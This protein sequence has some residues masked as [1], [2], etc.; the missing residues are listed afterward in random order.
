MY[1]IERE[2]N[3][4]EH[5]FY[6]N[7]DIES[8]IGYERIISEIKRKIQETGRDKV[9]VVI[10]CFYGIDQKTLADCLASQL[11]AETVIDSE[12]AKLPEKEVFRK[13]E[14]FIVPKDR[15]WGVM[16]V[17]TVDEFFNPDMISELRDRIEKAEG[18]VVVYGTAASVIT[19]GDILVY[20][21]IPTMLLRG[22]LA[23]GL[24]NWGAGNFEEEQLRK[25]KRSMFV[26]W[27][28]LNKHKLPLLQVMDYYIDYSDEKEP[29]MLTKETLFEVVRSLSERPFQLVPIFMK[30]VW[31]GHWMQKV[32]GVHQN[33][34]NLGWGLTGHMNIQYLTVRTKGKDML[35]NGEDLLFIEPKKMLGNSIFYLWGYRCPVTTNY[36]DTWGGGNLSLQVHAPFWYVQQYLNGTNGHHESYYMM[37]T[38]DHSSVYL[39]LKTGTKVKEMVAD[40][41]KAQDTGGKFDDE[42]YVNHIPMKKHQHVFIPGGTVHCSGEGTCVLEIDQYTIATFKL[43]DWGRVDLD[44]KPRPI[45]IDHGQHCI[46]E[47]FQTEFVY[48]NLIAKQPQIAEGDGWRCDDTSA[49]NYEPMK[50]HRYWISKSVDIVCH[51]AIQILV[52]VEGEEAVIESV[53]GSFEPFTVH[54]GESTFIPAAVGEYTVRPVGKSEGQEIA[55]VV[56][57]YPN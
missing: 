26:E 27:P 51:D 47:D 53:N 9:V 15:S 1:E 31:G 30:A 18:T 25:D 44:G 17:G 40:L 24:D 38:T 39:G 42:K 48:E 11:G 13:F 12:E 14:K 29:V 45:N 8:F 28:L 21:N 54:Y 33:A 46:Q 36:L 37:D 7:D 55:I 52:Q 20:A 56:I 43:Y 35:I 57:S 5:P 3:F 6:Q 19:R 2:P 16:A 34:Q 32:F 22:K 41:Q 10:D 49:M 50:I 23:M 4:N